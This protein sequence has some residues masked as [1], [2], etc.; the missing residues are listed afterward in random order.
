[1]S[2]VA[3]TPLLEQFQKAFFKAVGYSFYIHNKCLTVRCLCVSPTQ[4][5]GKV[6]ELWGFFKHQLPQNTILTFVLILLTKQAQLLVNYYVVNLPRINEV[7]G[8]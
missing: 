1:M 3:V 5:K 4:C 7:L 8:T 2:Y 6:D